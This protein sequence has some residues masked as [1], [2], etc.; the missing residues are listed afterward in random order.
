MDRIASLDADTTLFFS[1][2]DPAEV[3]R[4]GTGKLDI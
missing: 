2:T 3:R 4:L 1:H